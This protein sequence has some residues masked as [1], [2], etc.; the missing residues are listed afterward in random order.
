M[1]SRRTKEK[2][3]AKYVE[4]ARHMRHVGEVIQKL[5]PQLAALNP[6]VLRTKYLGPFGGAPDCFDVWFVFSTRS[7]AR[8]GTTSG[9]LERASG[10]VL[11]ALR[12]HSYPSEALDTFRFHAISEEQIRDAG[13]EWAFDRNGGD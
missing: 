8:K 11:D 5:E 1:T 9:T 12:S 2:R 4:A 7:D 3:D 6:P 13:G 10:L